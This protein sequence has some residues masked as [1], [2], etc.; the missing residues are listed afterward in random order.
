M[1]VTLNEEGQTPCFRYKTE[2]RELREGDMVDGQNAI[3]VCGSTTAHFIHDV[4]VLKPQ[5]FEYGYMGDGDYFVEVRV[6][7]VRVLV[8]RSDVS[9]IRRIY[10]PGDWI[11]A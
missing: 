8:R 3:T 9:N 7:H 6:R 10:Q 11:A 2:C 4:V 1:R 5:C